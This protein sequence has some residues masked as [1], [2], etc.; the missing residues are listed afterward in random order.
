MKQPKI[1][2]YYKPKNMYYNKN[3]GYLADNE[4]ELDDKFIVIKFYG[5][6]IMKNS[7]RTDKKKIRK[8]LNNYF[9]ELK[10]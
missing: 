3:N 4:M 7:K 1:T 8:N 2:N 9:K 6:K 5:C 10:I